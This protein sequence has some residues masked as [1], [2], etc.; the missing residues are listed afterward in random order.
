MSVRMAAEKDP[1]P[2]T[3]CDP[4]IRAYESDG[5]ATVAVPI[6]VKCTTAR[7]APT[8]HFRWSPS[9]LAYGVA[10]HLPLNREGRL[11]VRD[12]QR[13]APCH[14]ASAKKSAGVPSS[15]ACAKKSVCGWCVGAC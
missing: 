14:T 13:L 6:S 1:D 11:R 2:S 5:T 7:P 10:T 8:Q 3:C 4:K 15:R 12:R 9:W